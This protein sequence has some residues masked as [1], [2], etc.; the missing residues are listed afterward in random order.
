M[1]QS[2]SEITTLIR[3]PSEMP[4]VA[5]RSGDVSVPELIEKTR[6]FGRLVWRQRRLFVRPLAITIAGGL[7]IAFASRSEYTAST[8]LLPYRTGSSSAA[9]SGLAGLAGVRL[10]AGSDDQTIT[11]DL[12][13]V[14]AKTLDFR[15]SVAETPIRFATT[16]KPITTVKYF[17][18]H[19]SIMDAASS[20]LATLR[21]SIVSAATGGR[22]STPSSIIGANGT[23]LRVYDREYLNIVQ[24]LD[25]RLLVS[26]DKK[27]SVISITG[28]MP[29]PYAAADLVQ[30]ASE[31]LMQRII[32]YEAKK[33]GE[34]LIFIEE[35]YGQA[36]TRYEQAQ[37]NLALFADRNRSLVS[38][39]SQIER[40]RLQS[41]F[42]V[43]FN[44]YQQLSGELQLA[45][46]KK[47][48]DTPVFTVLEQVTVPNQR[49]SPRR[50]RILLMAIFVGLL[51]GLGRIFLERQ[52]PTVPVSIV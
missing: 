50:S 29:S 34:Q 4:P 38:P 7:L 22:Q 19:R 28:I 18:D 49:S 52:R 47:N 9:L 13:P 8:K 2:P 31:R 10:P 1:E 41:E 16:G 44:V 32:D 33:A 51:A 35:Q 40:D 42:N 14:L 27:T 17:Q 48:Q 39:L 36:K 15:I 46:I 45:R 25:N 12:Y 20:S 6:E 3:Y 26:I 43:A 21:Y 23:P 37:Q 30:T 24:D 5:P 11:A